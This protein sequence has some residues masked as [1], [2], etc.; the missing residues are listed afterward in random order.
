MWLGLFMLGMSVL[1]F[2]SAFFPEWARRN[3]R[4]LIPL[5]NERLRKL[6]VAFFGAV[7]LLAAFLAFYGAFMPTVKQ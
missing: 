2:S 6:L 4:T 5:K 1:C 7:F 3:N